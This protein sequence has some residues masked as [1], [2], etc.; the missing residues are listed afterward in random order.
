MDL[1]KLLNSLADGEYHSGVELG[2]VLGVSRTAV[3]KALSKLEDM[4]VELQTVKGRGYRIEG[5]LDLLNKME[6][7]SDLLERELPINDLHLLQSVDSTNSY[8]MGDDISVPP[9]KYLVC[10]AER[11]TAGRG[12]RGRVWHSPYAKN[13]YVSMAFNL[14]GGVEVLEGLSL[15]LGVAIANCLSERGVAD[16]GL[17]WPN[18]I[19]VNNKKLAGILV[20]LKGEAEVGWRVVAGVGVN[21]LMSNDG[22]DIDQPWTSISSL[23]GDSFSRNQ[24]SVFLIEALIASIERYRR[25]GLQVL[26]GDWRRYDVLYKQAVVIVGTGETGV[27]EGIDE[28]GRLLID[29]GGEIRV[30]NAG[31][32]SIR[33]DE[34]SN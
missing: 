15:A 8:L 20:E 22:G 21:V 24:W 31:E 30:V 2:D 11:Q 9:E 34:S 27:C 32:V 14:P 18:D 33:P 1:V 6:M 10:V 12:R 7:E 4:G 19:W 5:G 29:M 13:I 28:R 25:G 17:K 26:L 23:I 16:V 3:W